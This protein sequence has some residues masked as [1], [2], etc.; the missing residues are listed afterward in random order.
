VQV[1]EFHPLAQIKG[2]AEI[3]IGLS[4]EANNHVGG[5][6]HTRYMT[7]NGVSSR[8]ASV[9][10]VPSPHTLEHGV[11]A[12]LQRQVEMRAQTWVGPQLKQ[13]VVDILG[14]ERRHP[15]PGNG[16]RIQDSC[17]QAREVLFRG[18]IESV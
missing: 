17:Q 9:G 2:A 5:Y 18:K 6:C 10:V 16:R 13:S 14:L 7:S 1:R 8:F 4:G 11:A 12:R 3:F 15:D